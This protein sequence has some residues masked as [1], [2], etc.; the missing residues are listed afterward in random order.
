MDLDLDLAVT[1]VVGVST[2]VKCVLATGSVRL[3]ETTTL[4]RGWSAADAANPNPRM[5]GRTREATSRAAATAVKLPRRTSGRSTR[6]EH[7][8]AAAKV[9]TLFS[10]VI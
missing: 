9:G 4:R 6:L 2:G 8:G 3:A 1:V 10:V 5:P 7:L